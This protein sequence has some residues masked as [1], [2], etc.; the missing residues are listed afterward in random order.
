M[1]PNEA[2]GLFLFFSCTPPPQYVSGFVYDKVEIKTKYIDVQRAREKRPPCVSGCIPSG[3][4]CPL[5]YA[6]VPLPV[7]LEQ[8]LH[9]CDAH[10]WI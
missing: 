7:P 4:L 1:F 8:W 10:F 5:K 9:R 2:E 6:L 3:E